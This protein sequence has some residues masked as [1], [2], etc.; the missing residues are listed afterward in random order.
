MDKETTDEDILLRDEEDVSID[1]QVG[2]MSLLTA[3]N[4]NMKA[5][6]E[7]LKRFHGG[8]NPGDAEAAKKPRKA[9]EAKTSAS[10]S[11]LSDPTDPAHSA[12]EAGEVSDSE[13]LL[14]RPKTDDK[15]EG[16]TDD[17]LLDE[18]SKHLE[19]EEETSGALPTKLAEIIEKRWH[20]KLTQNK[21]TEKQEKYLK[22]EN[23][24]KL[25]APR[26]NK[27]IWMKLSRDVKGRDIKY[28][29]PQQTLATAGRAIAQSTVALLEARAKNVQPKIS[30]L[31]TINTDILALLGHAS[32]DL[33]QLRRDNIRLS[34]SEDY[35][36]LCSPQIPITEY[37]FGNEEDLQQ[38]VN[39]ITASNKI[40]KTTT[41][42]D[43]TFSRPPQG[44]NQYKQSGN[45]SFLG[46][47][48][49]ERNNNPQRQKFWK[50]QS[51]R[52]RGGKMM[53]NNSSP[54]QSWKPNT[55]Y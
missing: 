19:G 31:I 54:Q 41:K 20:N 6:G 34:L 29:Q 55:K 37:L 51:P 15:K 43:G 36:S 30:D 17:T 35:V 12:P 47:G 45:K 50:K 22:P 24:K 10:S 40:S 3:M 2:I 52:G 13:Q 4:D 44:Q 27:T 28:S 38:R 32:A 9:S 1:K 26:V 11:S 33:A 46:Q 7:S 16:V 14:D 23:C 49:P 21:L 39:D 18:I 5:M 53:Y 25:A 48:Y 42:K 8:P